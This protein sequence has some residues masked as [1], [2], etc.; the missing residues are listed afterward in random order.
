[1]AE[2]GSVTAGEHRCRLWSQRELT[3]P[4]HAVDAGM[5]QRQPAALRSTINRM[6]VDPGEQQL[7]PR[8]SSA[9]A[10]CNRRDLLVGGGVA[11]EAQLPTIDQCHRAWHAGLAFR[12]LAA[13]ERAG[14]R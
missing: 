6:A 4:R 5:N 1:M 11:N 9:L 2:R 10:A 13:L 3:G 7:P 12:G 14:G 8:H